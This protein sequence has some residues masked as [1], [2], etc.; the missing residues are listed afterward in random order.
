VNAYLMARTAYTEAPDTI[1]SAKAAEYD[2]FA[3]ATAALK[4][5]KSFPEIAKAISDNR[6]LW[7]CIAVDVAGD[8][9]RLPV[10]LRGN[11]LSLA[12]FVALQSSK[13]LQSGEGIEEL[14]EINTAIMSGLRQNGRSE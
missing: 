13:V 8:G 5:A 9:N 2:V 11:L 7:T 1:K 3:K 10:S 12:Q 6:R 4:V 14:I